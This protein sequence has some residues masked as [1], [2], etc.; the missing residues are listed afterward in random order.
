VHNLIYPPYIFP[1]S[2]CKNKELEAPFRVKERPWAKRLQVFELHERS[3]NGPPRR[4]SE[5]FVGRGNLE[6]VLQNVSRVLYSGQSQN[7]AHHSNVALIRNALLDQSFAKRHETKLRGLQRHREANRWLVKYR[8]SRIR[9]NQFQHPSSLRPRINA[10]HCLFVKLRRSPKRSNSNSW[11]GI[12][13]EPEQ[14][15]PH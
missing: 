10:V 7:S 14:P 5:Q 9:L 15:M 1:F 8:R 3:L 13:H 12:T 2:I 6:K 4:V 11:R